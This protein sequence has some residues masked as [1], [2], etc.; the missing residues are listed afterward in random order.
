MADRASDQLNRI[1]QLLAELSRRDR[2]GEPAPSLRELAERFDTKPSVILRDIR[3]ATEAS[4]D[5]EA[6]WLSSIT[7]Y[8]DGDRVSL[9][10]RGPYRRPI[11]FTAGELL[12]LQV[13]LLGDD[14]N[15]SSVLR[16]LAGVAAGVHDGFHKGVSVLPAMPDDQAAVVELARSAMNTARKLSLVYAGEGAEHPG[17]RV[18]YVHDIVAAEGSFYLIAWCER[19]GDWRRFRC[20]R[21]L[22]ATVTDHC[23]EPRGDVP[24]V[25]DSCDLFDAPSEGVD[26]VTTRFSP[27]ISRWVLERYPEAQDCGNG[28]A[29]VTFKTASIDW[30][31]RTVLQ[32]GAEA[33]VLAPS[34]YREA[35]KRAVRF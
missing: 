15:E 14:I 35:V 28:Y 18:V 8:Q 4:D 21:V 17:E 30:L 6:T 33:E 34:V 2:E 25:E 9:S 26:E 31:V 3:L 11:R 22:D 5:P 24:V 19:A 23:F 16:E 10:S 32:Y 13:A 27:V 29:E 7:A 12:A 20:D 1:V